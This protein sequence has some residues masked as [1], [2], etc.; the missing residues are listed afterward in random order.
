MEGKLRTA[1]QRIARDV[2]YIPPEGRYGSER[3]QKTQLLT[4]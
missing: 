2:E 1:Q 3:E 4:L